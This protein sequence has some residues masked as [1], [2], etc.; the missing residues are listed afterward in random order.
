M[1]AASSV[2]RVRRAL[3]LGA[4][5]A[6]VAPLIGGCTTELSPAQRASALNDRLSA[7]DRAG[8]VA[9]FA[10]DPGSQ[11]LAER[12]FANLNAT[13]AGVAGTDADHLQ[14]SW[15]L[16]REPMVVSMAAVV[17]DRGAIAN[18]TSASTGTEWLGDPLVIDTMDG[19]VLAT[20]TAEQA[21]RWGEAVHDGLAALRRVRPQALA[22][23]DPLV[24][25]V[26]R[27]LAAF[28]R[29]AGVG[30][31]GTAAVTVVPGTAASESVR[32]VV[33]PDAPIEGAAATITHEAVHAGMRS[34]RLTGTPGWLIEGTAEAL[35]AQAHPSVAAAN[36]TLV[37]AVLARGFP[38]TV[39][40]VASGDPTSYALAQVA[41]QAMVTQV[42]WTAVLAEAQ[43]RTSASGTIS[44]A[45][46]L[47]WYRDELNRR[48]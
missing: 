29:Y 40:D 46:V 44:D 1:P 18:L 19:G 20:A 42:G 45:R 47:Q 22:M 30:A 15:H 6:L 11:S 38:T 10:S 9:L 25:L 26:S 37:R 8:F 41:V 13:G 21:T 39:P 4:P 34:P 12:V 7:G 33:N 17:I 24:V 14:V 35:T 3:L 2:D 32:V 27:D 16:P 5:L 43:A 48:R 23:P 31:S 36:D 28:A